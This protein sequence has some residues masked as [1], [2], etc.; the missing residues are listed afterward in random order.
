MNIECTLSLS[1]CSEKL[2]ARNIKVLLLAMINYQPNLKSHEFRGL[3]KFKD[4][5]DM[6]LEMR[7]NNAK[8][9][10][11]RSDAFIAALKKYI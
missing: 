2:N 4:S 6:A 11:Q 1:L 7:D 9:L 3:E 8:W 5:L 10:Q